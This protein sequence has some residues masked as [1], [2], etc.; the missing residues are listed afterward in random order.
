[1]EEKIRN[2]I[3]S[4]DSKDLGL[5]KSELARDNNV[6]VVEID[7][8]EMKDWIDYISV[9]QS[10]FKFPTSC[11]DSVD[12]YLDWIRDLTWLEQEKYIII[13]NH[14]SKFFEGNPSM[15]EDIMQDFDEIILPYW[16]D[17]VIEMDSGNKPRSFIVYTID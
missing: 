15:K 3:K 1:M 7:G 16:Q 12:R 10:K 13:I 9:I 5:V 8:D 4:I 14:F 11:T 2:E 17:E 6:L